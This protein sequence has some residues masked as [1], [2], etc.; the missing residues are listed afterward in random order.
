MKNSVHP[1]EG[2]ISDIQG[3][4]EDVLASVLK[5][6][7]GPVTESQKV[8]LKEQVIE[9]LKPMARKIGG[10]ESAD[11][12]VYLDCR[13]GQVQGHVDVS[14]RFYFSGKPGD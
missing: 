7:T 6:V 4:I 5:G 3:Q 13:P 9:Q 10:R 11:P 12:W 1:P 2:S 14:L 8:V